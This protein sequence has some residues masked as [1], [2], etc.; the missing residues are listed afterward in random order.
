MNI[1][2]GNDML[3]KKEFDVLVYLTESDKT[4]TQREL[5]D[6]F[7]LSV[8]TINKVIKELT[9]KGYY[10]N[11]KISREEAESKLAARYGTA[12]Y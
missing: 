9:D 11:G 12:G 8:G 10:N 3:S 5:S 2:R 6:T 4:V 7:G 1:C